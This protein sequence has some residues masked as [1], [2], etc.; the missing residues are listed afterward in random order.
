MKKILLL[1]VAALF[2]CGVTSAQNWGTPD[3]HAKSSNTPIVAKVT[4]GETVQGA[5]TLGAFVG[6]ELRGLATIH[7]DGN[8]WIQAFYNEGETNPDEFTFKFYDGEQEYTNCTTTLTGQEE[9]YGT[10]NS[11]VEL[12]FANEQT[13]TQT[14]AMISGWNWWSTP[15]ELSTINGL[16]MLENSLGDYGSYIKTSNAYVRKRSNGTWGGSLQSID[17]STG[18]KVQTTDE[19]E[20]SMV[21]SYAN[22][23]N[24][25]ITIQNGWNWI[26]YPVNIAQSPADAL[27]SDFLPENNDQ[28][29]GQS[30]YARYRTSTGTW[31]PASFTLQPGKSYLYNSSS[32]EVKTFSFTV[33]RGVEQPQQQDDLF[34]KGNF[35]AY[36]DNN[37]ILAVVLVDG[38]EQ[39][40]DNI[41]IGAFVDGECRGSARL[42]YD[43]Y[44]DRYFAMFTITG[45]NGDVVQFSM[46]NPVKGETSADCETTL[47]F[48]A[49]DIVGDF[50]NPFELKFGSMNGLAES[51]CMIAYPN[52]VDKNQPFSVLIPE[53]EEI[54]DILITNSL[55]AIIR[56]E[57]GSIKATSITGISVTGVYSVKVICRSGNVYYNKLIVK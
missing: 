36:P 15:I 31:S 8:F 47:R 11:P 6:D 23:A 54:L 30:G 16:E 4:L 43:D 39:R 21:G 53:N 40:D 3:S 55:G 37:S 38:E 57:T 49:D 20:V 50:D 27:P 32:S 44:S 5:G 17:N 9:G 45:T 26:G 28:I 12:V 25:T 14:T 52:P 35:Y 18:Y 29:K 2:L 51:N 33:S 24:H 42:E 1:M 19:C 48:M 10:P 34:W 41:E 22:P 56:H 13:M 7:T 46:I